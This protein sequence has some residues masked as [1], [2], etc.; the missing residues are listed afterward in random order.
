MQPTPSFRGRGWQQP[1]RELQHKKLPERFQTS[2]FLF[3]IEERGTA[4]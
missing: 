1:D 2:L 4:D 3:L